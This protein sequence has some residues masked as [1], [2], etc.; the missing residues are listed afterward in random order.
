MGKGRREMKVQLGL[1][2]ALLA[3][4][5]PIAAQADPATKQTVD[6]TGWNDLIPAP[7]P[8]VHGT[9]SLVR[10]D[11][12]ISMT[13][14]TSGLPA[15]EPVT[16][17]WIIVDPA[18]GNVVSGQFAAGHVVGNKGVASFA[19]SLAEGNTSGCFHPAF[20]CAG[21]TDAR[22]Q[23][24]V[25]LARTHGPKNPGSLPLQIHTSEAG[26]PTFEDDLCPAATPGGAPFCQVQA[27]IFGPAS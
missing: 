13:F 4:L 21:L 3:L 27:A 16:I 7:T 25:L 5:L 2:I 22:E 26:G 6:V 20:P 23:V 14:R 10:R 15:G 17:W 8:D 1:A 18:T 12:G 24:V 11:D 19:G 9:A